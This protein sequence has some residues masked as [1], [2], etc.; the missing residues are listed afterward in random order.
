MTEI[1]TS[2]TTQSTIS[3]SSI[4]T[5]TGTSQQ[6]TLFNLYFNY[7]APTSGRRK[8]QT[9]GGGGGTS[10]DTLALENAV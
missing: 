5:S 9:G 1:E 10:S 2:S 6:Q 8:R 7:T 4:Q 3:T